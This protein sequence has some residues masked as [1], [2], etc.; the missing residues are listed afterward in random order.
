MSDLDLDQLRQRW[1][2]AHAAAEPRLQLDLDKLRGQLQGRTRSAFV[3]HLR[4]LLLGLSVQAALLLW[5]LDFLHGHWHDAI[6]RLFALPIASLML[7]Q[8]G[9][10]AV[11]WW[12]LRRLDPAAPALQLRALL[13]RLRR[14][15]LRVTRWIILSSVLLWFPAILVLLKGLFG[16]DL[17][18]HIPPS[19]IWVN[20]LVG[21][22]FLL[23][24]ELLLRW[25][26]RRHAGS[27]GLHRLLVETAGYSWQRAEQAFDAQVALEQDIAADGTATTIERWR[28]RAELPQQLRRPLR[29][30]RLRLLLAACG[31]ATLLLLTGL[32]NAHL[33]GQWSLLAAGVLLNGYW[34]AQMVAA[35]VHWTRLAQLDFGLDSAT[36]VDHLRGLNQTQRKVARIS[37]SL[38]PVFLLLAAQVLGKVVLGADLLLASPMWLAIA[39]SLIAV[40]TCLWLA[41]PAQQARLERWAGR[42]L[43]GADRLSRELRDCCSTIDKTMLG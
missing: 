39:L 17:I 26:A 38:A 31:W 12:Q 37:L 22:G 4:R 16:A 23:L 40:G 14:R 10:S 35:I 2:Q 1:Q 25:L 19:V 18:D 3:S 24:G 5:L 9:V 6:Y 33:G 13:D 21:L 43:L 20:L 36:L 28:R 34:I 7:A 27:P 30:L 41:R 8:V 11:Q 42:L 15:Q 32:F 29:R